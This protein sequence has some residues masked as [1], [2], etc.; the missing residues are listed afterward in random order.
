MN[1]TL[2]NLAR[3]RAERLAR[4]KAKDADRIVRDPGREGLKKRG[5]E[6]LPDSDGYGLERWNT[7]PNHSNSGHNN[8]RMTEWSEGWRFS[9]ETLGPG[10]RIPCETYA[11]LDALMAKHA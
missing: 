5:F 1:D 10:V 11:E 6:R 3:L 8:Y 7:V 4:E 2:K 9:C